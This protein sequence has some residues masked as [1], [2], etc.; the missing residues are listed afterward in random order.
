MG[1]RLLV[2]P[3]FSYFCGCSR[4]G[5]GRKDCLGLFEDLL[6]WDSPRPTV[7]KLGLMGKIEKIKGP[8]N[9]TCVDN[10]LEFRV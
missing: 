9:P 3:G 1:W 8:E 5:F 2:F 10:K 6:H 4:K 7:P